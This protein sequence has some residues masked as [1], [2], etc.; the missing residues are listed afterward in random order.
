VRSAELLWVT[1]RSLTS[2][3]EVLV[4][5][6]A[7]FLAHRPPPRC[8]A[9]RTFAE[10]VR[11]AALEVL[12]RDLLWHAWYGD[13][14]RMVMTGDPALSPQLSEGL[15]ALGRSAAFLLLPGPGGTA[16]ALACLHSAG[17]TEQSFGARAALAASGAA[18]V[19]AVEA[20]A[21]EALMVGWSMGS[22]AA[23]IVWQRMCAAGHYSPRGPLEH[24]MHT[25][26]RQDS[27]AHLLAGSVQRPWPDPADE[28]LTDPTGATA[29]SISRLPADEQAQPAP[30]GART[31]LPHPLG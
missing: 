30:A 25:F 19:Q 17:R 7:A 6:C 10:A 14:P 1:G 5:A 31:R 11:H 28:Q 13:G 2:D 26:H 16:C 22:T 12:E 20:A 8:A 18:L 21:H 24:A 29:V 3:G 15:L 4:P 23:H 9:P 27:L